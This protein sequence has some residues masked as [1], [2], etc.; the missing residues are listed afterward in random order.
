MNTQA[1][2]AALQ[3]IAGNARNARMGG[4]LA[5]FLEGWRT[6]YRDNTSQIKP[7]R[8]GYS[9]PAYTGPR[10]RAGISPDIVHRQ[11]GLSL[12]REKWGSSGEALT[13]DQVPG[14]YTPRTKRYDPPA[15][16]PRGG[17]NTTDPA[18]SPAYGGGLVTEEAPAVYDPSGLIALRE[19]E[20]ATSGAARRLGA[21]EEDEEDV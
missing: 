21:E 13:R 3:R 7:Q 12:G 4:E 10:T 15:E 1:Q 17:Y 20:A 8:S 2:L 9:A 6:P 19:G 5:P 16:G 18:L 14:S 11:R